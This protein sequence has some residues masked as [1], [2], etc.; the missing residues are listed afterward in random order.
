MGVRIVELDHL[1]AARKSQLHSN[2]V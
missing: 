2:P 1:R